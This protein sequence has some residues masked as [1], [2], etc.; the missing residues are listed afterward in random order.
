M[1]QWFAIVVSRSGILRDPRTTVE[2]VVVAFLQ[3]DATAA[4]REG[5]ECV[6]AFRTMCLSKF[7]A[8]LNN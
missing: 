1:A 5:E 2:N 6:T 3:T 7:G 4:R 8:F